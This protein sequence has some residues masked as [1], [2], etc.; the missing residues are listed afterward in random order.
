MYHYSWLIFVFLV[1]MGFHHVGQAGLKLLP[2]SDL[3][4]LASQSAGI[5]GLSHH[6]QPQ[7][8]FLKNRWS[9]VAQSHCNLCLP[10][11]SYSSASASQVAG[12]TGTHH[13]AWLIFCNFL[14]EMRFHHVGQAGL[15]LLTSG[16]LPASASQSAWI[17]GDLTLLP[18]LDYSGMIMV[19]CS[20]DFLNSVDPLTS[21][22]AQHHAPLIFKLFVETGFCHVAQAGLELLGS[23]GSPASASQCAELEMESLSPRLECSGTA[24]THCNL[25]LLGS[26]DS[27][28]SPSLRQGLTLSPWLECSGV[29]IDNCSLELPGS[30]N[31]SVS[32]SQT[33]SC[34]VTQAGVRWRHLGS[35][36][37]SPPGFKRFSYLSLPSSWITGSYHHAQLIFVFLIEMGFHHIGQSGL[38]LL[39]SGNLPDLASKSAGITGMSHHTRPLSQ[40]LILFSLSAS[41]PVHQF[42]CDQN[43]GMSLQICS[44]KWNCFLLNI[45]SFI[46]LLIYLFILWQGLT[47]LLRLECSDMIMA[48]CNLSLL[49]S[50]DLPTS[51][52]Q[53]LNLSPRLEYSSMILA[54]SSL[55][56]PGS[57]DP[58]TSTCQVAGTTGTCHH[59]RLIFVFFVEMGFHCAAQVG[60]KFLGSSNM[61]TSVSQSAKITGMSHHTD[62]KTLFLLAVYYYITWLCNR[63][64]SV[65]QAGVEC[66]DVILAHCS[67]TPGLKQSFHLSLSSSWDHRDGSFYAVL[68]GLK[69]L[70]SNGISF[71]HPGW[72]TVAPCQL[73]ATSASWVKVVLMP[74]PPE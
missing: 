73:T 35:L 4:A 26:S 38:K 42:A 61:P 63:S 13:H 27:P 21:A 55:H 14:V 24:L 11:S 39:T 67:L 58:P 22:S 48:H 60:L 6:T 49:G 31:P 19:H 3:P 50:S 33:E 45:H 15:E 74:Q 47:L 66:S 7:M 69:L 8:P 51:A 2:S 20:L 29:I 68:A 70:A 5:T 9:A 36:Q 62:L 18:Q 44:I 65:A 43:Y 64:H 34:S 56:L 59:S 28:A 54:H 16:Y 25:C 40:C 41:L 71:C 52:S 30:S 10:G 72:S 46:H 12:I 37:P 17:T 57:S 53:G 23:S 32:A 1:E